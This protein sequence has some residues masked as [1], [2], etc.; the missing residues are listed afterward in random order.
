MTRYTCPNMNDS[1][2]IEIQ[3]RLATFFMFS[4]KNN[5]YLPFIFPLFVS[6]P[7]RSPNSIH[8]FVLFHWFFIACSI[9]TILFL[10]SD[11]QLLFR[12]FLRASKNYSHTSQLD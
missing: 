8:L 6:Q 11:C 3:L 1:I 7:V 9:P 10:F 4:I 2:K 12:F 5:F